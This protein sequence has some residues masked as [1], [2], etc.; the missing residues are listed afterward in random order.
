MLHLNKVL[1]IR[2]RFD[3]LFVSLQPNPGTTCQARF[4]GSD[5]VKKLQYTFDASGESSYFVC[6]LTHSR[7]VM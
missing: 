3:L 2:N 5:L 1:S 7:R 6:L 4:I